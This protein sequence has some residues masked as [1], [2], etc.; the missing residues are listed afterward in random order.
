MT[1][2]VSKPLMTRDDILVMGALAPTFGAAARVFHVGFV[3]PDLDEAIPV[4]S[5]ILDTPFTPPMELPGLEI[6]GPDGPADP[7]LR[8]SY[9]T[10]PATV[11]LVQSVPGTLWDFGDRVRCHHLGLW[12]DDIVTES[13]RLAERGMPA[14]WWGVDPDT[15]STVFSFHLTPL[16]FYLELIDDAARSFYLDWFFGIDPALAATRGAMSRGEQML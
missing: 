2:A 6:H 11:E 8:F 5:E 3:V 14:T 12:T 7:R 16:G 10:R 4:M 15:G 9:S 1:D 13:D